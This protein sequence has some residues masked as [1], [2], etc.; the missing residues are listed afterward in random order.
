MT[1]LN[2][3]EVESGL[4]GLAGAYPAFTELITLPNMTYEGRTCHAIRIGTG[5]AASKDG[6]C[7]IGGV[8]A[9]EWGSCEICLNFVTDLLEAYTSGTGL[10]Y[11]GKSFTAAQIKAVMEGLNLYVFPSVNP[12]GRNYSQTAVSLWRR[13]RNPADSGGNPNCAGVDINRN[14]DFLWDFPN[15]YDPASGVGYYTSTDP[16][17]L[18]NNVPG[19]GTYHGSAPFSEA[20]TKNVRWLLDTYPRIKYFVDIHSYS[21]LLLHMW[22]NDNNQS[23]DPAMNFMNPA[24]NAV[25]GVDGDAAYKEYVPPDDLSAAV[26]MVNRMHDAIQA[27]RNINYTVEQSYS[28]YPTSGASGDYVYSRHFVDPGKNKV[29]GFVIEWGTQ[30]QP[31]WTEMENI[32]LDITAGLIEFC[33]AAPC[34]GG[35]VTVNLDTPALNFNDVPEGETTVRAAVF[36]IHSCAP[37]TLQITSGPTVITGPPGTSFGTPLGASVTLG[38]AA[39]MD[40]RYAHLWISYTGTQDGDTATGTVTIH[41]QETGDDWVIPL[42]ADTIHRPT[43]AVM[44][45]LDIS[46]SMNFPSGFGVELPAR[47]DVL[48]YSAQPFVEL[49][50]EN[51]ALGIVNFD[52]DAHDVMPVTPAG[53]PVFGLGRVTAK[54]F[55]QAYTP[56]PMGWTSIGDG[57]ELAHSRLD[58]VTGYD[59]KATI[60]F[61]DGE[62]NRPKFLA[63]VTDINERVYAIGLGTPEELNPAALTTLTNGTGGYL[64]LTGALDADRFFQLSKYFLQILAGVKN[65]DIVVDPESRLLP[66]QEHRIPF[67]LNEADITSEVVLLSPAPSV[68]Q[69]DLKAPNGEVVTPAVAAA[70]AGIDFYS[71]NNSSFYRMTLPVPVGAAGA[72]AGEWNAILKIDKVYFK[73]YLASL[74]KFP[75]LLK[76]VVTHGVRYAL[77]VQAYSSLRLRASLSQNSFAPGVTLTLRAV[78]TEHGLPLETGAKVTADLTRPDNTATLLTLAETEPGIFETSLAAMLSGCYRFRVRAQGVTLRGLPFTREQEVTGA[79]W[80]GGDNPPTS[81]Q[82]DPCET[83]ERLCRLLACLLSQKVISPELEKHLTELG[84]NLG[85]LRSCLKEFCADPLPKVVEEKLSSLTAALSP[86]ILELLEKLVKELR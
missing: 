25:R 43:A 50:P 46:N 3:T 82:D 72:G 54:G 19:S 77:T 23:T 21:Q 78:L 61:T 86:G 5:S 13:N 84:L 15:L 41:C 58:P 7:I 37:V 6:V 79:V 8:H 83:K 20:E 66:G 67:Y 28:L 2:V 70:T 56:N 35:L 24:Y 69:F 44:L 71:A 33:L 64:L 26:G 22:G 65:S 68:F 29:Y 17:Q 52:Q 32:I 73:R 45:V 60:V 39:T 1:Y 42:T 30:F 9:R 47:K 14:Y 81:C 63:D 75:E 11:G 57:V 27:V 59:I 49:I 34:Q 40:T 4:A 31:T 18:E 38:V 12:D 80:K 10:V 53:P 85:G 16:C 55:I 51:D 62:E 36:S 48:K 74:E 76:S